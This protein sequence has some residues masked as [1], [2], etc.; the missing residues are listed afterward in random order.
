MLREGE[1]DL[2]NEEVVVVA[3]AAAA[4]AAAQRPPRLLMAALVP[5]VAERVQM[6]KI[7]AAVNQYSLDLRAA[8]WTA[9]S[10]RTPVDL[11]VTVDPGNGYAYTDIRGVPRPIVLPGGLRIVSSTTP[12][13]FRPNGSVVG[14][15]TTV[16]EADLANGVTS[17]WTVRVSTLG[18][19][20]ATQERVES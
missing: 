9:V 3:M 17:R 19:P 8:R 12:I 14:G 15:A 6:A 11:S 4:A 2:D 13:R 5:M 10:S 18:M 1:D 7:R 16:I 20:K